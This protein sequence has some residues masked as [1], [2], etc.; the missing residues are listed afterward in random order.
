MRPI[1]VL[2]LVLCTVAPPLPAQ[3]A[4]EGEGSLIAQG[5][6][7]LLRGLIEEIRPPMEEMA[8]IGAEM[9]PTFR[10]LAR[11]MGPAFVE[12][13]EQI[14]S[15]R[16]Y[17]PPVLLPNGDIVLRRRPDAPPWTPPAQPA[18]P[19]GEGVEL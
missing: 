14:D 12:I 6:E 4:G 9:L 17:E 18:P 3:E 19:T 16:N 1:A 8:G 2:S 7:R 13:I 11:E 5:A 10:L 15:I